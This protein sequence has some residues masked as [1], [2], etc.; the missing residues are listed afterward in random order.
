MSA[1]ISQCRARAW[2]IF[3][4]LNQSVY[5]NLHLEFKTNTIY[6]IIHQ[7]RV[8]SNNVTLR[9]KNII[10]LLIK[11]FHNAQDVAYNIKRDGVIA[12]SLQ[13]AKNIN[14]SVYRNSHLEYKTNT[15]YKIIHK[16]RLVSDQT[17]S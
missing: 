13:R 14:Q 9:N 2:D 12:Y 16:A 1:I 4:L 15:I 6:K 3:I 7:A 17:F 10:G 8:V 5:L 11:P